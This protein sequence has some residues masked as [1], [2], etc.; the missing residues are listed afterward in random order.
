[1]P[2]LVQGMGL[3][4]AVGVL[5]HVVEKELAEA[6]KGDALQVPG[7]D[8]PIRVDVVAGDV[9]GPAGDACDFFKCHGKAGFVGFSWG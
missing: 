8:D 2:G 4:G 5:A 3:V 9:D 1:M 6:V 7:R